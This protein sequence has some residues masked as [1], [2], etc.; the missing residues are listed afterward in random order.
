[1]VL[2]FLF[3]KN[4]K[5]RKELKH[6]KESEKEKKPLREK[7]M[8]LCYKHLMFMLGLLLFKLTLTRFLLSRFSCSASSNPYTNY[9]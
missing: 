3:R 2:I 5:H 1:M 7:G 8:L 4:A 6:T 9:S